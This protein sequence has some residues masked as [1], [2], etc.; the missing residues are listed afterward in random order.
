M[1]AGPARRVQALVQRFK[2]N[3]HKLRKSWERTVYSFR[4]H[5]TGL[6]SLD[7]VSNAAAQGV[8]RLL[9]R[10]PWQVIMIVWTWLSLDLSARI[11]TRMERRDF[12]FPRL[13]NLPVPGTCARVEIEDGNLGGCYA[14]SDSFATWWKNVFR[15][16]EET[17]PALHGS[18]MLR[19]QISRP[20][21]C[22]FATPPFQMSW[23]GVWAEISIF[24]A[25]P[26]GGN[27]CHP[28]KPK[29]ATTNTANL[30]LAKEGCGRAGA[31]VTRVQ[32]RN[33]VLTGVRDTQGNEVSTTSLT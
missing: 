30:E 31:K 19:D 6:L 16:R 32:Y 10:K 23:C 25:R 13:G 22:L 9:W 26:S 2:L 20:R 7:V 28:I 4:L 24:K 21:C 11:G 12:T 33:K 1:F 17:R 14:L 29:K 15:L 27:H 8:K 3:S 5:E 18:K